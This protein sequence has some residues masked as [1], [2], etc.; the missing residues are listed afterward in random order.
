MDTS[1]ILSRFL[2]QPNSLSPWG[3]WESVYTSALTRVE[4][5]RTI[6]RLRLQGAIDDEVRVELHTRFDSF[7]R[8]VFRVPLTESILARAAQSFPTVLGTLD[9]LH[10]ASALVAQSDSAAAIT[11]LTHDQ[12]LG[13]AASALGLPVVG[14]LAAPRNPL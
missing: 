13:R 10:L 12:Q 4:F 1:V 14:V 9:A 8:A 2:G 6:D 5:M 11:L 7:W 3:K